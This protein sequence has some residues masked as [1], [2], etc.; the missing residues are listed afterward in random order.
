MKKLLLLFVLF[1][2]SVS[3][4]QIPTQIGSITLGAD[5]HEYDNDIKAQTTL[6]IR[7]MEYLDEVELHRMPGFK[8]GY[9]AY[10][11]CAAPGKIVRIKLKYRDSSKQFFEELLQKYKAQFGKPGKWLGDPFH[12]VTAWQ[13]T[14]KD[15]DKHIELYLQ[16]NL[17]DEEQKLGNSVKLTL[18][19]Q[20]LAEQSCF[21]EKYPDYRKSK[22][23]VEKSHPVTWEDLV[24][25]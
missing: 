16:H 25:K 24:P 6:P 9:I 8:S 4:A 1:F 17:S 5:I 14:F 10:A 22:P 23:K 3:Y 15:K 7:F 20:V 12:V 13:W 21:T 19:N 11:N 2:Q 18:T